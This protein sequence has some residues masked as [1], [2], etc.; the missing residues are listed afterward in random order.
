MDAGLLSG[1]DADGLSALDEADGI[2]LGIF[3]RNQRDL[4]IDQRRFRHLFLLGHHI[5]QKVFVDIQLIPSLFKGDAEHLFSLRR[6]RHIVRI[7]L[8]HIVISFFLLFQDVQG[9][10]RIAGRDDAVGYL[11][12]DQPGG[13][14]VADVGKGDKIA[15]GGHAVRP[16][17][18]C[19]GAGQRRQFAQVVHPVDLCQRIVQRKAHGGACRGDMF[20]R[21][22]SG[23][24]GGL[25]QLLYQL[26]AVEGVQKIDVAGFS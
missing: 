24:S 1:A 7:D 8:D 17:G 12:L 2:G 9:F 21:G 3:Q 25:L 5:G 13:V 19:V 22:G 4:H 23:Q 6:V 26:P 10:F 18:S 15:E 11:P 16:A 20:K 14:R